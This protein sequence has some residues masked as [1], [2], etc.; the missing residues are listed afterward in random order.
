MQFPVCA[1]SVRP[2]FRPRFTAIHTSNQITRPLH[3]SCSSLLPLSLRCSHAFMH[4]SCPPPPPLLLSFLLVIPLSRLFASARAVAAQG[5]RGEGRSLGPR[6]EKES[7]EEASAGGRG[8]ASKAKGGG[9]VPYMLK[10]S[11]SRRRYMR[12]PAS[13]V[14]ISIPSEQAGGHASPRWGERV[15]Q[16]RLNHLMDSSCRMSNARG[17]RSPSPILSYLP[18]VAP[19]SFVRSHPQPPPSP[20]SSSR[21]RSVSIRRTAA[22]AVTFMYLSS[23]LQGSAKGWVPGCVNAA[24]KLRQK[25]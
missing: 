6:I 5:K 8:E 15:S 12:H 2:S 3:I 22:A 7:G 10:S 13:L 4:T 19:R 14:P 24:G 1:Q 17:E 21:L 16:W 9:L 11:S 25:W 18:F 20:P 23:P